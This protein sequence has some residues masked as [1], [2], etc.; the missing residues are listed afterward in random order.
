MI[1]DIN[2]FHH[3]PDRTLG[4]LY[5]DGVQRC[6]TLEDEYREKKVKAHTRIPAGEYEIKLRKVG[7]FH[8]RYKKR[9]PEFHK[10]M[11]EIQD[12][13]NFKYVL[14]HCGNTDDDTAGCVLVGELVSMQDT[15]IDSCK[16]YKKLY[17]KVIAAM[18][19]G[20]DVKIRIFNTNFE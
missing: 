16:A 14:I 5:V 11:L 20:E 19:R 6:F 17:K 15:L 1:I 12:V 13:P 3:L 4:I 2:R 18:D 9:F 7:G 8:S 10:G